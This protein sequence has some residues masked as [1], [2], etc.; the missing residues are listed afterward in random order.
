MFKD[1][2]CMYKAVMIDFSND[3]TINFWDYKSE[4]VFKSKKEGVIH[5]LKQGFSF[6]SGSCDVILYHN[7]K[8]NLGVKFI[9]LDR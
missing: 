7:N 5:F 3:N 8:K 6:S 4:D 1:K 2:E 9:A